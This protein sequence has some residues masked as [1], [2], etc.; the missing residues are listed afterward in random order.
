MDDAIQPG[1]SGTVVTATVLFALAHDMSHDEVATTTGLSMA[2][3]TAADARFPNE[4]VSKIW[5]RMLELNPGEAL[6]LKMAASTPLSF[7]GPLAFGAQYAEDLRQAL[8]V[9]LRFRTVL[10]S[11]LAAGLEVSERRAQLWFRHPTDR[12]DRGAAAM[13]GL[14]LGMRFVDEVIGMKDALEGVSFAFPPIGSAAQ[15]Q[16]YFGVPVAFEAADNALVFDAAELSTA[17]RTRDPKLFDYIQRHLDLARE[18]L[19]VRGEKDDGLAP[20]RAALADNAARS[21]YGA[22][23]L[24][25]RMGMSLRVLQRHVAS[26]G[27]TLRTLLDETR[28]E[29]G[30]QL[31]ADPR[32]SVEE[33][34]FV[35]GYADERSFRR[36]F[37]RM[38]GSTPAQFRR[39]LR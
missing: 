20:L 34:A 23:A 22:E 28:E 2:E 37:K 8:D 26:H 17:P 10:S 4:V 25:K 39:S 18:R 13:V 5:R 36:A 21:E 15:Y 3:L 35:L 6:P 14:A 29:H 9:F 27:T 33:V 11:E 19:L 16:A 38:S 30:R 31:L 12:D 1:M 7:L 32:L 24:A